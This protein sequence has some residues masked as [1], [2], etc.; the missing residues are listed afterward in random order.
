MIGKI[1]EEKHWEFKRGF[2]ENG[3]RE[4]CEDDEEEEIESEREGNSG[5][6]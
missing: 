5:D 6:I 1:L 4:L 3:G 2:Y